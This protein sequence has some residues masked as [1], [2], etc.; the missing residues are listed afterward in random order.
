MID[1]IFF[2][3]VFFMLSSLALTKLNS[4]PVDL[5]TA[6]N[7]TKQQPTDLSLTIDKNQTI[8]VNKTPTS[9]VGLGKTLARASHNAPPSSIDLVI[10]VDRVVPYGRV[11][12]CLDQAQSV[13]I[14]RFAFM[15][16]PEP[17][18]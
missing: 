2:L 14:T 18:D 9:L 4:F 16:A 1:T 15:T 5:P 3:L 11:V 12:S 10:N 7:A 6:A 17:K 8:Y 13:G